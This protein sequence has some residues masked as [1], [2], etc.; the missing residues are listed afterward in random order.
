MDSKNS[1]GG[2]RKRSIQST[3]TSSGLCL[4]PILS[5]TIACSLNIIRASV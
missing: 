3:A 5:H 1:G 2:V 4:E